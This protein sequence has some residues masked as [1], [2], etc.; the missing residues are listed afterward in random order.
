MKKHIPNLI[1]CMNVTSGT[2]ALYAAFNGQLYIAAWLVILA[3]VFDFFDGFAARLLHVKSE[4]GKELDSLAD[5]V[6]FGVVPSVLAFFLIH[7]LVHGEGG[8]AT[9]QLWER[10]FM[11]VPLV[12]PAFS[13]YR[14]A[15]FNLD[16]R[17]TQS[18][19]GLPTPSNAL[20]WVMLVFTRY[21]EE[22]FF[23]GMWGK[24]W[25]LA[26]LALVL[27][28]LLISEIP[29][30]SLK[31]T[32]FSWKGNSLLYCFLGAVLV[33]FAVWG[34]KA[35]SCMI[36]VYILISCYDFKRVWNWRFWGI[37]VVLFLLLNW[38]AAFIVFP[39]Y[40][41]VLIVKLTARADQ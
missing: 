33:G 36:P 24:P 6:S 15:K 7:D 4:M 21:H 14:L 13:A 30:F 35:L 10:V 20:F 28:V 31:L 5:V 23:L 17:Q 12:I 18:F 9:I 25:L 34:V 16:V 38:A 41:I 2:V 27:A 32:S 29:M 19:I 1:T 22:A 3:M 11:C 39:A 8:I 40:L 26:L 37:L